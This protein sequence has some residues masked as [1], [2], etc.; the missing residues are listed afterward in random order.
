MKSISAVLLASIVPVVSHASQVQI[1]ATAYSSDDCAYY[2]ASLADL[3]VSIKTDLPWG[4]RVIFR[5][6]FH[7]DFSKTDWLSSS[8]EEMTATAAYTW[9]ATLRGIEVDSR[10]SSYY[11]QIQFD[12]QVILPDGS[13]S[14][15]NGGSS[16][17]FYQ[18]GLP[19]R[20]CEAGSPQALVSTPVNK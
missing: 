8:Q 9:S 2:S 18:A 13:T 5:Y 11:D 16:Y 3:S 7:D 19:S 20:S 10:G 17:G 12:F 14:Y 6:G 15:D 1:S 4:S